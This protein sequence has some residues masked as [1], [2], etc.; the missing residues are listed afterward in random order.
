MSEN[1]TLYTIDLS[2]FSEIQII[3]ITDIS[4]SLFFL[5]SRHWNNYGLMSAVKALTAILLGIRIMDFPMVF[6]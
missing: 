2:L 5:F 6:N 4:F 1:P 3:I